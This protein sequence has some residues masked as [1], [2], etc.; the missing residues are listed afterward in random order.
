[1][2]VPYPAHFTTSITKHAVPY[3]AK[4]KTRCLT[5][6]TIEH[7]STFSLNSSLRTHL[8]TGQP[9]EALTH[10]LESQ[11]QG[12]R[13]D[14]FTISALIKVAL[15]LKESPLHGQQIHAFVIKSSF[16]T[17]VVIGSGLIEMYFKF[18]CLHAPYLLFDEI[19]QRDVF[20]FSTMICGFSQN[21]CCSEA[22]CFFSKM[23]TERFEPNRMTITSVLSACSQL[24]QVNSGRMLH[25]YCLRGGLLDRADVVLQTALMDL[26]SKCRKLTCARSLFDKMTKRNLVTWN[27]I[28]NAYFFDGAFEVA[29]EL[30][31]E[32]VS[33]GWSVLKLSILVIVLNVC[34]ATTDL[35][36]GKEMHGYTLKHL[37][38][39]YHP[40][41]LVVYNAILN[42]YA[43]TGNME[44]AISLFENMSRR[45]V[46][47]W[48]IMISCYGAYGMSR[49]ALQIFDE[50]KD[51]GIRLDGVTF[52]SVLSAC[53]HGGLVDEGQEVYNSMERDYHIVPEMMHFVCMVDLYGRSGF[54]EKAHNFIEMMPA[55][56]D[57]F[58]W[59]TLLSSCRNHKNLGLGEY[60]ARKALELDRYNISIYL[61]LSRL[62]VDAGRWENLAK[63]RSVMKELGLKPEPA[64][65]WVEVKGMVY[66]FTVGDRLK[67]ISM[68][69]YE[70]L[71]EIRMA[72]EKAGFISDTSCV[73]HK[74]KE[75]EKVLDLCGHTEKLALAFALIKGGSLI[76]IGK[77]LRVC[78]DCHNTFKFVSATYNKE[79]ILKDPNRYHRFAQGSC[80]CGDFW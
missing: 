58:V 72:M 28:I 12:L 2:T 33:E 54:L 3:L 71:E 61:L 41:S 38:D 49:K 55:Q 76:R 62:Y 26:Y 14:R 77:N 6:A 24:R 73:S 46:V 4:L 9:R 11:K 52:V 45:N 34:G 39:N 66:K 47:T 53:S 36:K 59:G 74:M 64:C 69:I 65:S 60:A 29:L 13:P 40:D 20:L 30:F 32:M 25:G 70:Y 23:L 67:K 21:G 51:Y 31:K 7:Q 8:I 15:E 18:G 1:M 22:L 44:S 63:V 17:D 78:S 57:K 42:M 68:R 5:Y 43:K 27:S 48:T 10:F 50:M 56:P 16:V 80:S 79:I 37:Y 19:P 75:N 35:R